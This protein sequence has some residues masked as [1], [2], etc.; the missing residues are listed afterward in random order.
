MAANGAGASAQQLRA[1]PGYQSKRARKAYRKGLVRGYVGNTY[2]NWRT[3]AQTRAEF[4]RR[5]R[6]MKQ[7]RRQIAVEFAHLAQVLDGLSREVSHCADRL[8]RLQAH[9][10]YDA[11]DTVRLARRSV[12]TASDDC[13][14]FARAKIFYQ[15]QVT[16]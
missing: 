4:H 9:Y 14:A 2:A 5:L 12:S 11:L 3:E 16:R 15:G 10:V 8:T 1:V 7:R 13:W 6:M